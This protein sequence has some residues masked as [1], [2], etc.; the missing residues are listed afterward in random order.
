[1]CHRGRTMNLTYS[2]LLEIPTF[3][4]RVEYLR[5]DAVPGEQTF[6]PLR[7][8]NQKFYMSSVWRQVR[9]AVIARDLGYDLAYPGRDIFG[10][11]LVHHLNPLDPKD[12]YYH[13]D[14]VID[15]EN[16]ITVSHE[17]HLSVHFGYIP[18]VHISVERQPGDTL[19]WRPY[20]YNTK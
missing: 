20:G 15:P 5:L 19:L 16:L 14:S 4:E 18:E 3:E 8:I 9:Q 12:I 6:G 1:M 10:R 7:D 2:E 13:R 11:V 17:T